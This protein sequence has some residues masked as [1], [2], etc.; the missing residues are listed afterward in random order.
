MV[1]EFANVLNTTFRETSGS[2]VAVHCTHGVNRTGYFVV[3]YMLDH[4]QDCSGVQAALDRFAE[5]RGEPI[6]KEYLLQDL[7][8]R[9]Q[10]PESPEPNIEEIDIE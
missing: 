1:E 3:R 9:Y 6:T 8:T 7:H 5:V 4:T 10:A 2:C